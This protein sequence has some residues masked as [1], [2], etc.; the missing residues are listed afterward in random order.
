MNNT[1]KLKE[2]EEMIEENEPMILSGTKMNM[3]ILEDVYTSINDEVQW[4]MNYAKEKTRLVE[5]K[6]EIKAIL[7]QPI[8]EFDELHSAIKDR[9]DVLEK[10]FNSS[11]DLEKTIFFEAMDRASATL[12]CDPA[13]YGQEGQAEVEKQ[14]E[15]NKIRTKK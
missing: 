13:Y 4:L 14:I 3:G 9:I 1:R 6:N 2:F 7:E 12:G 8:T 10:E 11:D 15:K 5:L